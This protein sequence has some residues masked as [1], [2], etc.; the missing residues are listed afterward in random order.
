MPTVPAA[1]VTGSA[2][3]SP[4]TTTRAPESR[5]KYSTSRA[6]SSGFIGTTAAPAISAP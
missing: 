6:L 4:V 5:R 3:A 1:S 2:D